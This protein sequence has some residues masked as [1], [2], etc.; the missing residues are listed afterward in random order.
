[1]GSRE[2]RANLNRGNNGLSREQREGRLMA[3]A[4]DISQHKQLRAAAF[5]PLLFCLFLFWQ[6]DHNAGVGPAT[7]GRVCVVCR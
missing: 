4:V 6:P 1:M 5:V 3:S 7:T 2:P